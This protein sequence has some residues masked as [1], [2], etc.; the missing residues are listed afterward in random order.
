MTELVCAKLHKNLAKNELRLFSCD[1]PSWIIEAY[2]HIGIFVF[3]MVVCELASTIA[4]YSIG[5]YRPDFLNASIF[6]IYESNLWRF[7][8][9][10]HLVIFDRQN[11]SPD[12]PS[13]LHGWF[14]LHFTWTCTA[15]WFQRLHVLHRYWPSNDE[16]IAAIVSKQ[17]CEFLRVHN[18]LQC[19]EHSPQFV[20]NYGSSNFTN[21]VNL[22]PIQIYLQIRMKWCGSKL[23]K[24]LLQFVLLMVALFTSLTRISDNKHHE[25]DVFAGLF[26][27]A[28][29]A[30]LVAHFVARLGRPEPWKCSVD[31]GD[32][33]QLTAVAVAGFARE[34]LLREKLWQFLY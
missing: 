1:L 22:Q 34:T 5:R 18:G 12:V 4:K 32:E 23:F 17:P 25:S 14:K 20:T 16:R 21:S 6:S 9:I 28:A 27:G 13:N 31:V 26:V 33:S 11:F 29:V 7:C 19:C 3:G 15:P 30:L 10:R 8:S 24:H 2:R